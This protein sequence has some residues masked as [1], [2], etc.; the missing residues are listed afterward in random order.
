MCSCVLC[1][2]SAAYGVIINYD[3]YLMPISC[4]FWDCSASLECTH[5][6]SAIASTRTFSWPHLFQCCQGLE[7]NMHETCPLSPFRYFLSPSQAPLLSRLPLSP[8]SYPPFPPL[9]SPFFLPLKVGPLKS[10]YIDVWG[11][12][13]VRLASGV[14]AE[15]QP[16]LNWHLVPTILA[17]LL[18]IN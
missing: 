5:V 4:H 15:P 18:R 11:V 17:I 12:L 13:F 9:P 3:G 1:I 2:L 10:S 16:N 14:W 7:M 8:S 6:S